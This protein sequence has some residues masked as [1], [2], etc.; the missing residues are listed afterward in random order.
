RQGC[1]G[2][3][4]DEVVPWFRRVET[5]LDFPGQPWHGDAGP[6]PVTRY[7]GIEE[8]EFVAA[9]VQAGEALGIERIDDHNRP[10]P[11]GEA[12]MARSAWDGERVT[13]GDA[14]LPVD[15]TPA[16]LTLLADTAVADVVVEHGSATGV[17][18]TDGRRIDAAL[19]VV[20]AGVYG[21]PALLMRSGI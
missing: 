10:G 9:A 17:R 4:P 20:C 13:T 16:S 14:Y 3:G 21:S 15:R 1:T 5:D 19:V 8:G 2:W 6:I 18:L 7:P 11:V 12:A